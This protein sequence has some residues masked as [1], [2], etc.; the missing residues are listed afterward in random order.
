MGIAVKNIAVSILVRYQS[1]AMSGTEI[2][3]VWHNSMPP[4]SQ[5]LQHDTLF[6]KLE[7]HC[8]LHQYC[9]IDD[10]LQMAKDRS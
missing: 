9:N 1:T 8:D 10:M 2:C 7:R 5:Y 4:A 3:T 6:W